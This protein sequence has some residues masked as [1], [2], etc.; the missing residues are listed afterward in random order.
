MKTKLASPHPHQRTDFQ[1]HQAMTPKIEPHLLS[2]IPFT[3][4][5]NINIPPSPMKM[6][7]EQPKEPLN[8]IPPSN[9]I[10]PHH[11]LIKTLLQ[12]FVKVHLSTR[13][14]KMTHTTT[15]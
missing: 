3:K 8:S 7:L 9:T 2:Q 12:A 14:F 10:L 5:I 1:E 11:Q 6:N 4:G 13:I 15:N